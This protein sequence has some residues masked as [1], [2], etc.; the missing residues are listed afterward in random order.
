MINPYE[1]VDWINDHRVVSNS[2]THMLEQSHVDNAYN[3]GLEHFSLTNYDTVTYPLTDFFKTPGD[4]IQSPATERSR[5]SGEPDGFTHMGV[6]GSVLGTSTSDPRW[7]SLSSTN[8]PWSAPLKELI[9]EAKKNFLFKDTGVIFPTHPTRRVAPKE[10]DLLK[11]YLYYKYQGYMVDNEHFVGLEIYNQSTEGHANRTGAWSDK[12]WDMLL[13][14]GFKIWG[15]FNPDHTTETSGSAWKGQN[16]LLVDEKTPYK[17]VKAYQDGNFYMRFL[18]GDYKLERAEYT[19]STFYV[20]ANQESVIRF[21]TQD[22]V[23]K[24]GTGLSGSYKVKSKDIFVRAELREVDGDNIIFTQP[25]ILK[26]PWKVEK[27]MIERS[28]FLLL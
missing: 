15:H 27:K 20:E 5:F 4:I 1:N 26:H 9:K 22:G 11:A 25:I 19:S 8:V 17:C 10:V 7:S 24:E 28:R 12:L 2:H 21:V 14:D 13:A 6:I 3:Q 18:F 23:V 16:I